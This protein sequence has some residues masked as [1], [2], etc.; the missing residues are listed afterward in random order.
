MADTVLRADEKGPKATTADQDDILNGDVETV[1][2]Y[3]EEHYRRLLWKIDLWLLPLMWLCYGTQQADKTGISTQAVFGIREDTGLVGEQYNW[4][5]TIFYLS[6]LVC[7]APGNWLMQKCNVGKFLSI[8]MILWGVVVLCIAFAKNFTDLMVLRTIQGALE[9]TIS[10]TFVLIT[11]AWYTSREHT[12]R[13]IIWGTANAGMN[14]ITGLSMYGIGIR[15][16]QHPGGLA[17]WKGISFLLGAL[18]IFCGVLAWFILGTPRE[19]RWLSEDEKRA[20]IV[21]VMSNKTGS[22]R[23]KR[24]EFKWQ[25][26][27]DTFKDP[28]TY[29]FFLISLVSTLPNGA[30]TTFSKLIWK[31]FGFT[32][33]QTL[34]IGSVPYYCLSICWFLTVGVITLKKPGMRFIMMMISLVVCFTGMMA[35]AFLPQD[36]MKWTRWGMYMLQCFG[37]LPGLFTATAIFVGYCV[38]NAVGAQM[39]RASDAPK[40]IHG[41]TAC[42]V[43]YAVEFCGM[44]SWRY[45]YIWQNRKRARMVAE[46]GISLEDSERLGELNAEADMTDRDNIHFRYQY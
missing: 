38:G 26:V 7:E 24:S 12:L 29:F 42:A 16:E 32:S 10:P 43:L 1:N 40:Y 14:I 46:Q 3:S 34:Y 9:C 6:Y 22:D 25:Q 35:L 36:S 39:F 4:L 2:E 11:G 15:A 20:A 31:S 23:E 45:Y 17:P 28:Q 5:T 30:T 44:A 18:T 37:A 27:R 8:V 19:V 41:L 21:R 13:S 33:L